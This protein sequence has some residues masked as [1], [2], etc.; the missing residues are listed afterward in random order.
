MIEFALCAVPIVTLLLGIIE[1]SWTLNQQQDVRYAAREGARI[2]TV[3]NIDGTNVNPTTSDVVSAICKRMD[4]SDSTVRVAFTTTSADY[5]TP[6]LQGGDTVQITV[7]KSDKQ[8]T[9]FFAPFLNGVV[10]SSKISFQLEQIP[11]WTITT[12]ITTS[13]GVIS[14]G[15]A[16]P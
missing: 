7:A 11:T 13:G 15:V 16:C 8:I 9:G 12:P 5:P 4:S 3:H 1:F 14:G 10:I 6:G 2:A